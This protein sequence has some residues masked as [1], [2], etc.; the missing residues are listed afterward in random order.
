MPMA[1]PPAL[2]H[3]PL[4]ARLVKL[5]AS[6]LPNTQDATSTGIDAITV[7]WAVSAMPSGNTGATGPA[8]RI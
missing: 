1:K 3:S 6:A 8:G 4:L 7:T 5:V 2:F